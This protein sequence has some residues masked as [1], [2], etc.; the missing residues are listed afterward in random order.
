MSATPLAPLLVDREDEQRM[1]HQ[2]LRTG[3]PQLALLTGRRR[4]GKTFLLTH[5]W[6]DRPY[7]LFT[8]ARTTAEINRRQLVQ[9]LAAWTGEALHPEDYP[10]WRAVFNLLLDLRTPEP[11]VVV[12]DE[13]QYLAD[14]AEGV[15]AVDFGGVAGGVPFRCPFDDDDVL[16]GELIEEGDG[17]RRE[18]DLG[19]ARGALDEAGEDG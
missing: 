7:F 6:G 17:L 1:L 16:G 4:V 10:T 8:A 9:D 19:P 15:G 14:G 2:L 11:L 3:Q 5:A 18:D 12:L 13:F